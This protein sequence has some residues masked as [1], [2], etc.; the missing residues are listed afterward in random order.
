MGAP[1]VRVRM[2]RWRSLFLQKAETTDEQQS[3]VGL[4]GWQALT[5][6]QMAVSVAAGLVGPA[7]CEML[8]AVNG[9]LSALKHL[10]GPGKERQ[11]P[12][13][14]WLKN[15]DCWMKR[16]SIAPFDASGCTFSLEHRTADLEAGTQV[17]NL[18]YETRG[19]HVEQAGATGRSESEETSRQLVLPES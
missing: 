5:M 11:L 8:A 1:S 7:P 19:C 9:N 15:E 14:V 16:F 10:D 4:L 13:D 2:S 3:C 18:Q 6:A 12:S 17:G